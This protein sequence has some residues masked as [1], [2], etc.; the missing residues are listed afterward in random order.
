M[1][2]KEDQRSLDLSE[3]TGFG[4]IKMLQQRKIH[5][6]FPLLSKSRSFITSVQVGM[7]VPWRKA[8]QMEKEQEQCCG[9]SDPSKSVTRERSP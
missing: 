7:E 6:S 3:W 4:K 9:E 1:N 5:P 2:Q 8:A